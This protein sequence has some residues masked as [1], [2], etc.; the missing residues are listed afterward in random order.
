MPSSTGSPPPA[1]SATGRPGPDVRSPDPDAWGHAEDLPAA[2]GA[3]AVCGVGDADMSKASGRTTHE[4][5]GQAVERALAD[6]GLAPTDIDGLMYV[7]MP[8]Q[9]DVAAFHAW[10]GTDHDIWESRRG[11]GM[12]GA[13]VAPAYAAEAL[14]SG[15]ARYVL[16]TFGVAWASQRGEM[17]GGPGQAHAQ[18]LF[19]QNLEIP[20]GWFPQPVYFA[21][22]ARRHRHEFGTT[23]DQLGAIAVAC[24]RHANG[25]PAAVM[26]DRPLSLEQYRASPQF[27]AP[28]RKEDC[29]LISDGGAAA[30]MTTPER[31]ADRPNPVVTVAGVGLGVSHTGTH[32]AQQSAFLSTPAVF[33]A[34]VAFAEAGLTPADVD[35]FTC[36]DPFTIVTLMQIEDH[37]FC[38]KGEGGSFVEGT[39][40]HFD[41]GGLPH[42]T[43]GGMLSHAYDLGISH[44]NEVVRQLRGEAVNQVPDCEVGIYGGYTGPQGSTLILRRGA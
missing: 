35:L 6:A 40:L 22:M 17:T 20:F 2:A 16:N 33:S 15:K 36:Y 32:W 7:P 26:H 37:G 25:N 12:T 28:F 13:A 18:D 42:N 8:E 38:A 5:V 30:N 14:R 31:A 19:K 23:E 9:F 44:V 39:T 29:C 24:R 10:F 4:I 43:H 11:G 21:T 1:S 41:G 27:V 3:V 34:P